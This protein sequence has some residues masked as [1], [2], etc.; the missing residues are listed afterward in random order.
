MPEIVRKILEDP[1]APAVAKDPEIR[2][3]KGATCPM[4]TGA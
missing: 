3:G 1:E 4:W 2:R